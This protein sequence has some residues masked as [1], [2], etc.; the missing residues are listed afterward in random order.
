MK[1]YK[2]L[3]IVFL[4][5]FT[6]SATGEELNVS[7]DK[8]T[9]TESDTVFLTIDYTGSDA[10]TLDLNGLQDNFNIV[11]NSA[12]SQ[13]TYLNGQL[14]QTKRWILGLSPKK[15]GK[16]TI[17]PIKMGN[18]QSNYTDVEVKE[19]TNVA[20]V[21]DSTENSNSP[22]FQIEQSVEP[23]NPYIQ[24]QVTITLT[25]Y[26]S[27]GLQNATMNIHEDS[28]KDWIVT[29]LSD[30]PLVK[31]DV[32]NGKRMNVITYAFAAF[33]Q[34]SGE[35][36]SPQISF[37]GYYLKSN[38]FNFSDFEDIFATGLSFLDNINQKV[39]VR[40][41]TK[42]QK[43]LVKPIP[44]GG[45]KSYWLPLKSL[46][47]EE[48]D[49]A[50]NIIAGE[51]FN[52]KITLTAVGTQEQNLPQLSLP[53]SSEFKQYP[54]KPVTQERAY[55]GNI[56]T[57]STTNIVYIP[58]KSGT[59]ILP[60]TEIQWFNIN[61]N[62]YEKAV[63]PEKNI[64]VLPNPNVIEPTNNQNQEKNKQ[65]PNIKN[66]PQSAEK[67]NN[68]SL[69]VDNIF[70]N[71][72][73]RAVAFALLFLILLKISFFRKAKNPYKQQ[74]ISFIKKRNYPDAKTALINWAKIKYGNTDINNFQKIADYTDNTDF[75]VQLH[76]LNKLLYSN[77][78]SLFDT[79]KFIAT[80][81]KVDKIKSDKKKKTTILP[82]L[83]E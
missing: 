45:T 57:T 4:C 33:P 22:Y 14:S 7:V 6:L 79:A 64:T 5:L 75:N 37:E 50:A 62:R 42:N 39:P 24:Q 15:I 38:S 1:L 71:I 34:K 11:S 80:F 77:S 8:K 55:N 31:Q 66:A 36:N 40:M 27:I 73:L 54:E 47:I 23:I 43:I 9:L 56:I 13:F 76:E 12:S 20:Y 49:S 44:N 68:L 58:L 35:L 32:I 74:V 65:Q 28:L 30:R 78:E 19:V 26:D 69:K 81:K 59:Y 48:H 52:R 60:A 29:P 70:D 3:S 16:I 18:L 61:T 83:Y 17:K 41:R 67:L 51:A 82:N 21:P 46:V 72:Y 63:L 53:A 25:I 10:Q 2:I